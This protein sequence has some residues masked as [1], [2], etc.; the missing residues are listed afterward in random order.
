[1][2]SLLEGVV[3]ASG[4]SCPC[5]MEPVALPHL[6]GDLADQSAR[7]QLSRGASLAGIA[8]SCGCAAS[9]A[10]TSLGDRVMRVPTCMESIEQ[11]SGMKDPRTLRGGERHA[12]FRQ[13]HKSLAYPTKAGRRVPAAGRSDG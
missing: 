9:Q 5:G 11:P 10:S 8:A 7:N 4:R 3:A 6:K 2:G 13:L 1:M 12:V